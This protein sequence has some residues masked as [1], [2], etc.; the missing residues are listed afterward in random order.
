ME[1]KKYFLGFILVLLVSGLF[2]Q[3]NADIYKAYL[4][5][6]MN[7]WKSNIDIIERQNNKTNKTKLDLLNY[8]YG[9]IVYCIGNDKKNEAEKYIAKGTKIIEQLE[10]YNYKLSL[11]YAYKAAF[12]GFE[13]GISPYKAPLLGS[14]SSKFAE[15]S[16]ELDPNNYFGYLQLGNIAFHKPAM[17]G[18]SKQD[19]LKHYLKALKLIEK[20]KN[21]LKNNWNYLNLL[22]CIIKTYMEQEKYSSAKQYCEKTL[23]FEPQFKKV[24][25]KLYPEVIKKLK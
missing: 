2:A 18:G 12:I 24:K 4:T 13:I 21:K 3:N 14:E 17:F 25:N 10:K 20:D 23:K 1:K 11:I 6:D 22:T 15:K 8:Q 9:Y 7:K 16:V 19:A 5:E